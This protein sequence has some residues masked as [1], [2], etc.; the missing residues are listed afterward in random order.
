MMVCRQPLS[1]QQGRKIFV[2]WILLFMWLFVI[3]GILGRLMEIM[4][5]G[6]LQN[7][8]L[9]PP[10]TV[11]NFSLCSHLSWHQHL[12]SFTQIH[13]SPFF[14]QQSLGVLTALRVSFVRVCSRS[15]NGFREHCA[16]GPDLSL[17]WRTLNCTSLS[18]AQRKRLS[19]YSS[20]SNCSDYTPGRCGPVL[21][22]NSSKADGC[23][24]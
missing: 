9:P 8:P 10:L 17:G 5:Q 13:V 7:C 22:F 1:E 14:L 3:Y 19:P 6:A 4:G 24:A 15:R 11:P 21:L 12:M 23:F 20:E 18:K 16:K 2:E